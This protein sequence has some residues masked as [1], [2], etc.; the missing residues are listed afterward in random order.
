MPT[1]DGAATRAND[2]R[3][4]RPPLWPAVLVVIAALA[5]CR[6]FNPPIPR[7]LEVREW[8]PALEATHEPLSSVLATL[9]ADDAG[10]AWTP[11]AQGWLRA[12]LALVAR[13]GPSTR[14]EQFPSDADVLAYLVNAHIA[15]ALALG[16]QARLAS[17]SVGALGEEPFTV[18]GAPASLS[19][20]AREIAAR[21][22]WEP[23]LA[24]FLN[25]GWRGG[26]P[27]PAAALEG[28]AL[29]WQLAVHAERCGKSGFWALDRSARRLA[30]P[31]YADRIWGLPAAQPARA[32]RL[33]DL[34]PPPNALRAE[35]V[36]ACGA[37]LQRCAIAATPTDTG[38]LFLPSGV[39]R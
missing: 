17:A 30:L 10:A 14:P 2:D 13:R 28:R 37:S 16:H 8:I 1:D 25:P 9:P 26:P 39:R 20:L 12:Y 36:A 33:L 7:G 34:V 27:L 15:G 11:P 22:P 23:R 18:D 6:P 31:A 5:G 24:L 21:A 38:R 29:D 19:S 4:V 3:T 35:I 32:R